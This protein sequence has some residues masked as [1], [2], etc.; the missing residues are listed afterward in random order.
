MHVTLHPTRSHSCTHP[1]PEA[2]PSPP[3]DWHRNHQRVYRHH[4][5]LF[6]DAEHSQRFIFMRRIS[7]VTCS[8]DALSPRA[9][10][11]ALGRGGASKRP[12]NC[13]CSQSGWFSSRAAPTRD[14]A[15]ENK[16]FL[17]KGRQMP[18]THFHLSFQLQMHHFLFI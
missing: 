12:N 17:N 2:P 7:S 9:G 1:T 11:G 6:V 10:K 15:S 18:M 4:I 13:T 8:L 16:V 3:P 14:G 5:Q